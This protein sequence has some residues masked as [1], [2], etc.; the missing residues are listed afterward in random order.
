MVPE[1]EYQR[2][3]VK[4]QQQLIARRML[5]RSLANQTRE[6]EINRQLELQRQLDAVRKV[7]TYRK[8]RVFIIGLMEHQQFP[9][10]SL[11]ICRGR[12]H[13]RISRLLCTCRQ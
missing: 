13:M 10:K 12:L 4:K 5:V 3:W 11:F 7:E 9:I 6:Y 2:Q 8:I 1:R